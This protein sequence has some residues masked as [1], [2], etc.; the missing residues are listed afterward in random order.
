MNDDPLDLVGALAPP[1][2]P[3]LEALA[4]V[5]SSLMNTIDSIEAPPNPD[6]IALDGP[7]RRKQRKRRRFVPIAAAA[8]V[9]AGATGTAWAVFGGG[10]SADTANLSCPSPAG[11]HSSDV[12]HDAHV[13]VGVVTGDPV[14]DCTEEWRKMTTSAPP[15]MTAYDNGAGAV[16]VLPA[17][18][19]APAG[20]RELAPGVYQHAEVATLQRNLDDVA[21]GLEAQCYA[22][23]AAERQTGKVLDRLGMDG[24]AVEQGHPGRVPDGTRD[25]AIAAVDAATR[26]VMIVGAGPRS[27]HPFRPF[28]E[29]VHEAVEHSCLGTEEASKVVRGIAGETT[30][31]EAGT[32]VDLGAPNVVDVRTVQ[33]AEAACASVTVAVGGN[34]AI[35]LEGPEQPER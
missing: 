30:I 21:T 32:L 1:V 15:T 4:R 35:T 6:L 22:F 8:M 17:R 16:V 18:A 29:K 27:D 28:A 20:Y 34:V 31:D 24:W 2:T 12:D 13:I 3:D 5:R 11:P 14:V 19:P 25:C 26:T 33:N 7:R 9:L 23:A 10:N